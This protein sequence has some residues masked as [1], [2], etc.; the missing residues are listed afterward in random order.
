MARVRAPELAG[1]GGW[2]GV[3]AELSL[4]SLRGKVVLL[5]FW[6]FSC[7]NCLRVQRELRRVERRFPEE[8]VVVGVHSPK[9]PREADHRAVA[10][11]VAR[12]RVSHPVLD[13]PDRATWSRYGVRAWPTVV[14]VDPDGYVVRAA[15]GE[16]HG[17]SL[18][19][20]V[21][22]VV[23]SHR[24]KGTLAA[25][26]LDLDWPRPPPGPLAYPGKVAVSADG[27]RL[28]IAD[29]GHDQVVVCSMEG[30]VLDVH[31]G[32]SE[33][34]GVRFEG[35]TVVVCD[36]GADR[37]VRT[38]GA[39]VVDGIASPWDLVVDQDGSLLVAE[40]AR[41][42]LR[43]VRPGEQRALVAAGTGG[44]G[45]ED[46]PAAQALL[47]QPSGLARGD[48]GIAFVDAEGSALRTLTRGDEVTTLVG[49]GVFE[50]GA[51]DG[52]PDRARLQHPL[53]V[54]WSPGDQRIYV[55]DT[56]NS[57]LRAWEGG[58]LRTLPVEGLEEPGGIDVLPDGRLVVA[59]TNHHRVVVVDPASGA[60]EPL[61]LDESW[62]MSVEGPALSV[63]A[64][65]R[66]RLPVAVEL[67]GEELDRSVDDPVR[68]VVEARPASLLSSPSGG[69]SVP[70]ATEAVEVRAGRPGT[71]LLL[72]E[73]QARPWGAGRG[74]VRVQRSRHRLEVT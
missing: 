64:G 13:D 34:Q 42:R 63:P 8:L 31:S 27:Q 20:L 45:L 61:E 50:W 54:A 65:R 26:P 40:A 37:V 17:R 23:E 44:E 4:A 1:S 57:R 73:V 39:V 2:I 14:V 10:H 59:D 7:L 72:V 5:H 19:Q 71:G 18:E 35:D 60:V 56:F 21:A 47:A 66:L 25:E 62:V 69:W 33:P 12:H 51:D 53:G 28:A 30:L 32:F 55:A 70:A 22:E 9:Y 38:D 52:P 49:E 43:R 74:A 36:S 24:A 46:G 41:H 48:A 16:G 11:A 3:D 58:A 6:T 15:S 67:P 29:T 68:V